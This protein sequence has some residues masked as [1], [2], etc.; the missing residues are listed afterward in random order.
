MPGPLQGLSQGPSL[1]RIAPVLRVLGGIFI[2]F[3]LFMIPP[4]A[5]DWW[6][7]APTVGYF[8]GA[9]AA[10]VFTGAVCIVLSGSGE[11]F[12]LNRKQ[13]FLATALG[14]LLVPCFA[15]IPFLGV[16]ASWIDGYF[17]SASGITTTGSTVLTGL[18][19][20]PE[21]ILLWRSLLQWV[22]GYG[23]VAISVIIMPFLRV[24]GMQLFR[25]E[26]TDSSEKILARGFDLARWIG[27]VY[28]GLSGACALGYGMFGM[29][30]FDAVN[31][32]MA[33][34]ATG[35]FSTHDAS[36]AYFKSSALE[37]VGVV[38]MIA[39]GLPFVAFIRTFRGGGQPI[40][41]DVQ[42]R[43]LVFFI[44]AV[45]LILAVTNSLENKVQILQAIR[46]A[47]FNVAS[48]VT[49][50]GFASTDYQLWGNF[51]IGAFFVITFV[52]SC[53]G[54]TA[55]GIKIYRL[56]ILAKTAH[57]YLTKLISPSQVKVITYSTRRVG[58]DVEI[59]I[60]A[61]LLAMLFTE[62]VFTLFLCWTGLDFMTS[63]SAV[64]QAISNVGPGLGPIVGPSGN[65]KSLS[66]PAKM[67]IAFAM[68]FGRL[69]YFPFFILLTPAFW[70]R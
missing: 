28:L 23:I 34:V 44:A 66:D 12:D 43:G 27:F 15:A 30:A 57:S 48:I 67:V 63:A 38:F 19:T 8:V 11:T 54:S 50:T 16:G 2:G 47:V 18:D 46:M 21:G 5:F 6:A 41:N 33:T 40:W 61:F 42:A 20:M 55:G 3:G 26:S 58:Q 49:T 9:I 65:Y 51:A 10:S 69:E 56:Q 31:H 52:G 62:V 59:A 22:G 17:E 25:A 29:T 36:F 70:R 39:G 37:W 32:A 14:W 4:L 53:S 60:L 7:K 13:A 1:I 45:A 68:I 35:G 64:A 24:G